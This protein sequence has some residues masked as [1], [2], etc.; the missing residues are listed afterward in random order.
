MNV[1]TGM[2]NQ[3]AGVDVWLIETRGFKSGV[4]DFACT[5][6]FQVTTKV[7]PIPALL[8]IDD[9]Y[10]SHQRPLFCTASTVRSITVDLVYHGN[11]GHRETTSSRL[12]TTTSKVFHA[13][14]ITAIIAAEKTSAVVR[15]EAGL[16][17]RRCLNMFAESV[18][19]CGVGKIERAWDVAYRHTT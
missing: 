13:R 2:L 17:A 9:I 7:F 3:E 19:W 10:E 1:Y 15:W 8:C 5:T 4:R 18:R 11:R 14:S 6:R 12:S 16:G